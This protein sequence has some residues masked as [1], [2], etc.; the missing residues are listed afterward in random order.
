ML[1]MLNTVKSVLADVSSVSPS[2]RSK[3]QPKHSLR[4]SAYPH[5]P[6]TFYVLLLRRRRPK[7]GLTGTN[8]PLYFNLVVFPWNLVGF[9]GTFV[10]QMFTIIL[11]FSALWPLIST[12]VMLISSLW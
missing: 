5:Q 8:I 6:Y 7:L 1:D 2:S 11:L 3:R 10:I 4:R 12:I 9:L